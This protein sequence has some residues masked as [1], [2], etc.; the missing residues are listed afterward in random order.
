MGGGRGT[1][2][3]SSNGRAAALAPALR[4]GVSLGWPCLGVSLGVWR[5]HNL[6]LP[7]SVPSPGTLLL[8]PQCDPPTLFLLF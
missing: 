6:P 2:A 7:M 8:V 1:Q 5:E 4:Y 3:L